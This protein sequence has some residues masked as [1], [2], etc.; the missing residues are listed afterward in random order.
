MIRRRS[1][2]NDS[3]D[4]LPE[5]ELE[6]LAVLQEHGEAEAT[7]IRETL[8]P[9]RPLSHASVATLLRRLEDRGLVERRKGETG[10]AFIYSPTRKAATTSRGLVERMLQRIFRD[11]PVSLVASLFEVRTPDES[12][13]A[14]LRGLLDAIGKG[15]K[16]RR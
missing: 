8:K 15:K 16:G 5:A 2:T 9:Y 3:E 14:E 12:E 6:V 7:L 13:I 11:R 4:F 1:R 10:R